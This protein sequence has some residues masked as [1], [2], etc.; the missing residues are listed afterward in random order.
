MGVLF[1]A[2]PIAVVQDQ[3]DVL[4][5]PELDAFALAMGQLSQAAPPNDVTKNSPN[6]AEKDGQSIAATA[7]APF[8]RGARPSHR[9][10]DCQHAGYNVP[11]TIATESRSM[12]SDR[13]YRLVQRDRTV[14]RIRA[15]DES[16]WLRS[17]IRS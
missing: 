12:R 6:A 16:A 1:E 3:L 11:S 14:S 2:R 13:T 9:R 15:C 5:S 10:P 8:A 17:S 7:A 4:D